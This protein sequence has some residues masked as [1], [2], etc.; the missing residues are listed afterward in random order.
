MKVTL[1]IIF[2]ILLFLLITLFLDDDQIN[3]GNGYTYNY[4]NHMVFGNTNIPGDVLDFDY[5]SD[6]IIVKQKPKLYD[7]AW[8][9]TIEYNYSLGREV[10]YYWIINKNTHKVLGPLTYNEYITNQKKYKI[11]KSLYFKRKHFGN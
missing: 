8:M 1:K 4:G 5:N 10:L 2:F 6:F 7:D 9:D 11:P 3:L